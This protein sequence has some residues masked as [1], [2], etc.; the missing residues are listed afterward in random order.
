MASNFEAYSKLYFNLGATFILS[1]NTLHWFISFAIVGRQS[2]N[3][4][5]M[6]IITNCTLTKVTIAIYGYKPHDQIHH[7][8]GEEEGGAGMR[9]AGL[10]SFVTV[11][12][13]QHG[14]AQQNFSEKWIIQPC[15]AVFSVTGCVVYRPLQAVAYISARRFFPRRHSLPCSSFQINSQKF[16]SPSYF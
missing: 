3:P 13:P 4:K 7:R 9:S 14:T 10:L 16:C 12:S 15:F 6:I 5:V 8:D 11:H 1:S 2:D